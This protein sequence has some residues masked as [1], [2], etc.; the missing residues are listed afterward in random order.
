[1]SETF[2]SSAGETSGTRPPE[3]HA[4]GGAA[5]SS[6]SQ[7]NAVAGTGQPNAAESQDNAV[8][9]TGQ[10]NAAEPSSRWPAIA[11]WVALGVVLAFELAAVSYEQSQEWGFL[12]NLWLIFVIAG[13]GLA[14]TL[15]LATWL[16]Y[17]TWPLW[18]RAV[19]FAV[20]LAS[21]AAVTSPTIPWWEGEWELTFWLAVVVIGVWLVQFLSW[22]HGWR[23]GRAASTET[24]AAAPWLRFSISDLLI[25]TTGVAVLLGLILARGE[26]NREQRQLDVAAAA[27][28]GLRRRSWDGLRRPGARLQL[29]QDLLGPLVHLRRDAG[30]PGDVDA[31]ALVGGAV[32][33]LVQEGDVL[34]PFLDRHVQILDAGQRTLQIG[35][36]VIVRGEQRPAADRSCRCSTIAQ[37]S[38]TPS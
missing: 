29:G 33:D 12:G 30:Q 5:D 10:P 23:I 34:F 31:V 37:A 24:V 36:L 9:G 26:F 7:D 13:V 18:G 21:L 20:G 22:R 17:S 16:L 32:D 28:F 3:G 25:L 4:A 2:E 6:E 15:W 1:M 19:Y 8:A 14:T 38:E 27:A 11:P 35:Q